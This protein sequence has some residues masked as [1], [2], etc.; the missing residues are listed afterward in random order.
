M[1]DTRNNIMLFEARK[2]K[3][4]PNIILQVLIFAAVI[5]VTQMAVGMLIGI[6][7][8]LA[9]AD[10]YGFERFAS[11][12]FE[13]FMSYVYD[14][15]N[16]LP[17]WFTVLSLF[18]TA[19]MTLLVIVYCHGIDGRSYASMGLRRKGMA[20]NYGFG[21]L[22][23]IV[24]IT[25]AVALAVLLGGAKFTGLNSSVSVLYIVVFFLGYLVQGMSEEVCFRGYFMVSCANRVHVG[26]AVFLSSL[27][28][29]AMHLAN[30]GISLFAFINLTLFGV[31][32][33][34]YVLRTDDL[35]GACAIHSAWN[36][37]QGNIFGISVSGGAMSSSVFGTAFADGHELISGGAF[38]IEGGICTTIVLAVATA[39][40]LFLP[41][42]PRPALSEETPKEGPPSRREPLPVYIQK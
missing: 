23:G 12:G 40:V 5:F 29:S 6:P 30:A 22:I 20:K 3:H 24:M 39:L 8:G 14:Y 11:E 25:A 4:K 36:F 38:G 27:A 32:M 1:L 18:E 17:E 19:I 31:F 28:F 26:I 21:Y 16:N 42:K 10:S 34:V 2:A 33:A 9:V 15:I 35:W 7:L 13:S 41:Q 37:F